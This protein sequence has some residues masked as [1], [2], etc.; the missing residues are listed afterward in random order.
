[1]QSMILL[2]FV[3]AGLFYYKRFKWSTLK[4]RAVMYK[5]KY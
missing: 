2:S 4:T 3:A 5:S 1:M